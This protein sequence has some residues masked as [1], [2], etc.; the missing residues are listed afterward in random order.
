MKKKNIGVV[1]LNYLAYE[2]TMACVECFKKQDQDSINL[3]IVI[4]DNASDNDS[5]SILKEKYK[6]DNSVYVFHTEKNLGYAKGNNWGYTKLS[7]IMKCDYVIISNDDILFYEKD[8]FYWINACDYKYEFGVLGPQIY[9]T[10][11]NFHQNPCDNYTRK[12]GKCYSIVL[13]LA[14]HLMKLKVKKLFNYK[15]DTIVV[16]KWDNNSYSQDVLN[17]TLH[18]SFLIFSKKYFQY[19]NEPFNSETFLYREE[20]ILKLRC[21][22]KKIPM[23]YSAGYRVDHLQAMS[24]ELSQKENIDKEIFRTEQEI[25][26]MFVYIKDLKNYIW[27]RG[28]I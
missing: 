5:Y 9:S 6:T 3:C 27:T 11:G 24:T 2:A 25:K 20:D 8:L 4:V 16:H 15:Y 13:K 10:R 19:Y 12:I 18:G 26:S 14:V 21:D 1:I 22:R 7:E 17:K 23:V 28:T